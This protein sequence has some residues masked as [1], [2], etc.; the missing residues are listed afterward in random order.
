LTLQDQVILALT[1]WR[2][3]RGGGAIGMQSVANVI[4]NRAAKQNVSVW[5]ICTQPLQFSSIT[6]KGDP[7]L[8]LW[9][10]EGDVSFAKALEIADMANE[11]DLTD[12]TRGATLYYAPHGYHAD[13]TFK[14]PDTGEVIP[15]PDHWDESKVQYLCTIEY[16]VFFKEL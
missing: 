14:L 16:Q 11:G 3:N 13:Q 1:I 7:E 10:K 6:T 15:F 9:P 5:A 2:E 4:M 12:L 8:N